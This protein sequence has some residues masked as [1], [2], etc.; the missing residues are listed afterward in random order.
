MHAQGN[1]EDYNKAAEAS[2][3]AFKTWASVCNS[4]FSLHI[5]VY[6]PLYKADI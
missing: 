6:F 1:L 5:I 4:S 2:Q 3:A